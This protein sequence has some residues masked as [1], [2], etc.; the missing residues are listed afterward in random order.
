MAIYREGFNTVEKFLDDCCAARDLHTGEIVNV[1]AVS[2]DG[3]FLNQ[4]S[5]LVGTYGIEGTRKMTED[6]VTQT[7]E[8]IDEWAVADER[9][10]KA[11]ATVK[12]QVAYHMS[13]V[14]TWNGT[15]KL[16][17]ATASHRFLPIVAESDFHSVPKLHGFVTIK[18][19]VEAVD[20]VGEQKFIDGLTNTARNKRK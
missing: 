10:T 8:L 2:K 14:R 16:V 9:K 7:I 5:N 20:Y 11:E 6:G 4:V 19:I 17:H 1:V 3:T 13:L 15:S 18:K 12:Y